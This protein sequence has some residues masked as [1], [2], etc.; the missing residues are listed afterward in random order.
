MGSNSYYQTSP[1][2][3]GSPPEYP[4]HYYQS[5]PLSRY[6][7]S[8][9]SS[10]T[11]SFPS[12]PVMSN[13][14]YYSLQGHASPSED[15]IYEEY[16]FQPVSSRRHD[17]VVPRS[18]AGGQ[19]WPVFCLYPDCNSRPFKRVADLQRHYKNTHAPDDAKDT[20][21]CDYPKCVR[22]REPFHRRDHFRDHLREYH[23]EDIQKRGASI[24]EEWLNG[25]YLSTSWWRCPRCLDRVY[26][27]Q[28]DFE[29]PKCKTSCEPARKE[30][31][32]SSNEPRRR[33]KRRS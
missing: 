6:A 27:A 29:C 13:N 30:R 28:H 3:H 23:K 14:G 2:S 10:H 18:E 17:S 4:F 11:S 24:N 1:V 31:R 20:Y 15:T 25:R 26:V 32:E 16:D 19:D 9:G 12:S 22:N 21:W 33:N 5:Q 7:S 8:G